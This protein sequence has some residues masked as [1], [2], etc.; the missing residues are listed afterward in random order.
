MTSSISPWLAS[1]RRAGLVGQADDD[2]MLVEQFVSD[3]S[4]G[5]D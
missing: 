3:G 2:A 5:S 4:A 1:E